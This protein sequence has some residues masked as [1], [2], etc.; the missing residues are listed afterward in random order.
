MQVT[1]EPAI[2]DTDLDLEAQVRDAIDQLD[3]LNGT[4]ARVDI[5][6]KDGHVTLRGNVQSPMS[7]VEVEWAAAAV[8]G[9]MSVTNLL[10]DD[11]TLSRRVATALAY[12]PR[13]SAIPPG[14]EVTPMFGHTLL[15]G[16]FTDE[17]AGALMAVSQAVPDVLS[18]KIKRL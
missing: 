3:I 15:I 17:Q 11:G 9:V 10:A 5:E 7:C 4:Q 6:V 12:D 13:T 2:T 8:P 14:Y 1:L 16:K 18:V